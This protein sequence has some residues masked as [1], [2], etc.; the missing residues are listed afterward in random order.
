MNKK[1][2]V[3]ILLFFVSLESS[4]S[5]K[6]QL[7]DFSLV[8]SPKLQKI[9]SSSAAP[10]ILSNNTVIKGFT[11]AEIQNLPQ[12]KKMK[13][14]PIKFHFAKWKKSG[15]VLPPL[16]IKSTKQGPIDTPTSLSQINLEQ[17]RK[18]MSSVPHCLKGNA[19]LLRTDELDEAAFSEI[20]RLEAKELIK[21]VVAGRVA[22]SSSVQS[23]LVDIKAKKLRACLN[24]Y[25]ILYYQALPAVG[26][27]V[28]AAQIIKFME[29]ELEAIR[30]DSHQR[31]FFGEVKKNKMIQQRGEVCNKP[32][33]LMFAAKNAENMNDIIHYYTA[34]K[35]PS[36]IHQTQD[37]Q[38]RNLFNQLEDLQQTVI[39]D[40]IV[41]K[42]SLQSRYQEIVQLYQ[43]IEPTLS[44]QVKMYARPS[45]VSLE[46]S[47][48]DFEE[49]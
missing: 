33:K 29:S 8:K 6:R 35:R 5:N 48:E 1:L 47:I 19:L 22:S 28:H 37:A 42:V 12:R 49:N 41:T 39:C 30:E 46:K 24:R 9:N 31:V 44:E 43:T 15:Y 27:E 38:S 17:M 13:Q 21:S 18:K 25:S 3:Y 7:E 10:D 20:I 23:D 2:V 40:D 26:K 45:F 16:K 34:I 14:E 36:L 32:F 11:K 4:D